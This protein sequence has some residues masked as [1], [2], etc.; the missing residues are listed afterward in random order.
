MIFRKGTRIPNDFSLAEITLLY[1]LY[2]LLRD[3]FPAFDYT[4]D[5]LKE[6]LSLAETVGTMKSPLDLMFYQIECGKKYIPNVKHDPADPLSHE[7]IWADSALVRNV[8]GLRSVERG[9]LKPREDNALG[10]YT[11]FKGYPRE[12]QRQAIGNLAFRLL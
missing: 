5:G 12:S 6:L 8:D 9:G 1:A 3:W 11:E 2:T 7:W 10:Y 4:P